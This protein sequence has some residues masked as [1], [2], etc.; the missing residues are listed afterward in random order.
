[1]AALL[2]H[3]PEPLRLGAQGDL[4]QQRA[5]GP[6]GGDVRLPGLVAETL[7]DAHPPASGFK[8]ADA[9]ALALINGAAWAT[10]T[11]E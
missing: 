1:M 5:V 6:P 11:E 2:I 8:A 3:P 4:R 7:V 9:A 10:A